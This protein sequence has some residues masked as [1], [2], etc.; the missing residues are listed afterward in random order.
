MSHIAPTAE[1]YETCY[2]ILKN[3]YN[4][5]RELLGKL[6][7]SILLLG[8][9]KGENSND[10]RL[11]HD[12]TNETILAIRNLGLDTSTW[13][14]FINH[15]LL[16]KLHR[17][18]IK[19]YECQLKNIKETESLQEFLKY[20]E[21]RCLAIQSSELKSFGNEKSNFNPNLNSNTKERS[22]NCLYCNELHYL[23]KCQKFLKLDPKER[24]NY[25]RNKKL[26]VNCF[27]LHK[28]DEC[29]SK[30][31]CKICNKKHHYLLHY[32]REVKANVAKTTDT[33]K[34]DEIERN[35][36]SAS[37]NIVSNVAAN[38]FGMLAT[39]MVTVR[40]KTGEPILLKALVCQGSQSSFISENAFQ[41]LNLN[42]Q[43]IH[44]NVSGIGENLS[45]SKFCV[46][47]VIQPRF[48]SAFILNTRALVLKKLTKISSRVSEHTECFNQF[49]NLL[50]ADPSFREQSDIDII[51]GVIELT[52]IIR[53]GLVKSTP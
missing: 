44:A 45:T 34:N 12:T 36:S 25:I 26:C 53:P 10:L 48:K 5:K 11:L 23:F 37:A 20:I 18:T 16:G 21:S 24:S 51:L 33:T 40:A 22:I 27:G 32:G 4:N 28:L 15:I 39:A 35:I 49:N 2:A 52:A 43:K 30:Y 13:D 47:L 14:P 3:R 31:S 42:R 19:H 17:D 50:L 29:R 8:K 7:D 1:N 38:S 6:F 41:T 46:D 9:H